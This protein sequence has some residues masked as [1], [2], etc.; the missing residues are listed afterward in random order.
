MFGVAGV[1]PSTQTAYQSAWSFWRCWC[2]GRRSNPLA[3]TINDV[4]ECLGNLFDQGRAYNTI[5]VTRSMLSET[6]PTIEG[7]PVGQH[8]LVLKLTKVKYNSK[9]PKPRY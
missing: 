8:H 9:P 3:A 6:L 7:Q 1:R 5:N 2:A 4:L